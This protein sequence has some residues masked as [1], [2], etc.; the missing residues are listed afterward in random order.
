MVHFSCDLCGKDLPN[1]CGPR[2]VVKTEVFAANEPTGL[3]DAD[4]EGDHLE[5]FGQLLQDIEDG[6]AEAPEPAP[7][8]K[9]FR[10]DL[11]PTCHSRFLRDPLRKEP[12]ALHF[13]K[14]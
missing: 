8:C 7:V 5:E 13:S 12:Q 1:D 2:Y 11:C 6:L 9:S 14:N 10:F 3:T 4:L